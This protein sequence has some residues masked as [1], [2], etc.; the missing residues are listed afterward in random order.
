MYVRKNKTI[1]KSTGKTYDYYKLV[2]TIQTENG[3]RQ[4]T[5]LHLGKLSITENERKMLG[6]LIERRIAGKSEV[7]IVPKLEQIIDSAVQKYHEKIALETERQKEIVS[8][9]YVEIDLNST[10]QSYCRSIGAELL[11]SEFWSRLEFD[12]M[13]ETCRFNQQE[14]ELAK[15]VILGRLISPGSEKRT[16][17][18]FR[19][20]SS[21]SEFLKTDLLSAGK[22]NF[23]KIGDLLYANKKKI[24][25]LLRDR[26][27]ALF[28]YT[29]TI[30]LYDL[31]NTYFEGSK[32]NSTLCKRGKSK[33]KRSDCPLVTLALVVDQNGFPLYSKI[34]R[35][36][37][38]GPLTLEETL[39]KIKHESNDMYKFSEKPAIA[40]D[41]GIATDDNINYLKRNGYS[42]FVIERKQVAKL[43]ENEF[44]TIETDGICYETSSKQT[45]YL[46]SVQAE[47][48][49]RVLV[50]SKGK[51]MKELSMIGSKE[52]RFLE[53][54]NRLMK[55][56]G[57]GRIRDALKIQ[58]RIGRI[59]ERYGAISS[60]Y[61]IKFEH[62][63]NQSNYIKSISLVKKKKSIKEE[64]AGCYVIE[65]NRKNLSSE[66]IWN[67]YMKLHEVES[68]F[69]S[70][71]SDLGTRPI[72]HRRDY[73]IESH[74]F[75]S[76]L[77]YSI[78][79]SI[80]FSLNKSDYHKSW[81]SIMDI[82]ANHQRATT[83]QKSRAGDTYYI[84]VTGTPE[85]EV[86]EIYDLLSIKVTKNIIIRKQTSHL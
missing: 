70:L 85:K 57:N 37:Q 19:H 54:M 72:Y 49:T 84:R 86:K 27:K 3:P 63:T 41:R 81:T 6:K 22:D 56:N 80:I 55:S 82:V 26:T 13:L 30:Y 77:A 66:E 43:Y 51:E 71:K 35:G 76:I 33:Q 61:E 59:K 83:I 24:E 9:N 78:L 39:E 62:E 7:F 48:Y 67:F 38:S 10:K 4:R 58:E 25:R 53:D 60:L 69:R 32:I 36:N 73:R 75:I 21:L 79:K 16:I 28:P 52:R 31:T 8:A 12:S 14:K 46:K 17:E 45:V 44:S 47:D 50:Y 11:C 1:E 2:E 40:M 29:D 18:W 34:Y 20:R 23:Y 64:L 5:V 65:T 68:A 42:Y 74:L 15:A